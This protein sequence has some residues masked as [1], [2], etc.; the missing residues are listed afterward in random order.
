MG[1]L[2]EEFRY[3]TNLK[4]DRWRKFTDSRSR[5]KHLKRRVPRIVDD[6]E[7]G[8]LGSLGIRSFPVVVKKVSLSGQIGA[9]LTWH[10][11][12]RWKE[13]RDEAMV[14][15][16][17]AA[18]GAA[19]HLRRNLRGGE[20]SLPAAKA[21]PIA[22]TGILRALCRTARFYHR[23]HLSLIQRIVWSSIVASSIDDRAR[24]NLIDRH[25]AAFLYL[26]YFVAKRSI[27]EAVYNDCDDKWFLCLRRMCICKIGGKINR[28]IAS[29][30]ASVRAHCQI[31]AAIAN[32][33]LRFLF[34]KYYR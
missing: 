17:S 1:F 33:S 23:L 10:M 28:T 8:S 34:F 4:F 22:A 18:K 21:S 7:A 9:A 16:V 5:M 30:R 15:G 3:V 27:Q 29:D 24:I 19:G 32:R 26:L 13:R 12:R 2:G 14:R 11:P 31:A 6:E 20:L 25:L